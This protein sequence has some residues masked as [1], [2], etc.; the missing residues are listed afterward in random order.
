MTSRHDSHVAAG[1][2]HLRAASKTWDLYLRANLVVSH[3]ALADTEKMSLGG[4]DS[5]RGYLSAELRGDNGY[6]GTIELRRQ[7]MLANVP[8]VFNLFYDAGAARAKGFGGT[9]SIRSAGLG[10]TVFPRHYLR[11]KLEYAHATSDRRSQDGR[12]ERAWL[13]ITASY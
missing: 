2:N 11:A 5:V 7:F 4:P 3:D 1:V 8:G 9:D 6:Q 13:T 10:V 12:R